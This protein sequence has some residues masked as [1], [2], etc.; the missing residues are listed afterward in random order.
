MTQIYA[1]DGNVQRVSVVEAGPLTVI[2]KRT[3]EKDGYSALVLGFEDRKGKHTNK[4]LAGMYKKAN[5][6]AKR[7]LRE[8][9]ASAEFCG[10]YEVGQTLKLDEVFQV[11]QFIDARGTSRGRGF[12]GVVRRYMFA[13][14]VQTHGTHEYRRHGGSIGT[15]MTP[16]R[17]LP[18]LRMPGQYGNETVSV[19]NLKIVRI[20]P[21]KHL[22][23]IEG[24]IPGPQN[25]TV[26]IRHAVKKANKAAAK[27]A[28]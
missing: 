1:E 20:D 18:N 25:G 24:G 6:A 14:G 12:S 11:G 17:T 8:V 15:N 23:L 9:R 19:M 27:A 26:L 22:L 7:T 4:P 13:G 5:Q 3:V 21:E 10:K 28:K 16:G 2:G